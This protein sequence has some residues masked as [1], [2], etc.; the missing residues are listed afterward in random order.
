M[1][2]ASFWLAA[3]HASRDD[4]LMLFTVSHLTTYRYS[5]PIRL[6]AHIIRLNP[7]LD[8]ARLISRSLAIEPAPVTLRDE[9]DEFG[10][11]V[12]RAAFDGACETFAIASRFELEQHPY[13]PIGSLDLAPLPWRRSDEARYL[14]EASG[15]PAVAAYAARIASEAGHAAPAFLD[16]LNQV[17]YADFDHHIRDEGHAF[18]PSETLALKR[19]AC[20]DLTM[21]FIA[22]CRSLGVPARFVSGY[23]AQ[24]DTPDGRRHLHA[25]PEALLPGAGWRGYDPTHGLEVGD[26]HVALAVAPSQAPTM[27]VEGGYW[28]DARSTLA[29]EISIETRR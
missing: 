19:G 10:N 24:A 21:L 25:W 17:L 20:R 26:G 11:L 3:G 13:P 29:Y 6:G 23:Q 15:D 1:R 16:R 28:G 5:A 12:T 2:Q 7:R 18:T 8:R 27:P 4:G 14:D 22:C 9:T